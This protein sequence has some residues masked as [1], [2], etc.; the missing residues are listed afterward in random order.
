MMFNSMHGTDIII[1]TKPPSTASPRS[2]NF[3]KKKTGD[4]ND[5]FGDASE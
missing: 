5:K 3:L 4:Y 1:H 2:G